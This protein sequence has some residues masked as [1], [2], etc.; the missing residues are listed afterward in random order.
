[1][2]R[3]QWTSFGIGGLAGA[4]AGGVI[5]LLLAP[6][7]GRETR[8]FIRNKFADIRHT[9]GEKISG[10]ECARPAAGARDG[11]D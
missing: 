6:K 11:A 5:A 8:E 3:E 9:A 1:M 10:E 4:V 2:N 7:T